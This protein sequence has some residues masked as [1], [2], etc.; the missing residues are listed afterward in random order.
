[1]LH[2]AQPDQRPDRAGD[3]L[4]EAEI[5]ESGLQTARRNQIRGQCR[6]RRGLDAVADTLQKPQAEQHEQGPEHVEQREINQQYRQANNQ[7][8]APAIPVK[9]HSRGETENQRGNTQDSHNRPGYRRGTAKRGDIQRQGAHLRGDGGGGE[10]RDHHHQ[11]EI[12]APD[13]LFSGLP[14]VSRTGYDSRLPP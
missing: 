4:G 5:P 13:A 12:L 2:H 11:D 1:M 6:R 7:Q 8:H 3:H 14:P 10:S 9:Q